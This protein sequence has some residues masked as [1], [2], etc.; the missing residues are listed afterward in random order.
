MKSIFISITVYG[1][2]INREI[3]VENTKAFTFLVSLK[4]SKWTF[5]VRVARTTTPKM[6]IPFTP[7]ST[8]DNQTMRLFPSV[9]QNKFLVYRGGL[10]VMSNSDVV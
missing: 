1:S 2:Q 10:L 5:L 4:L 8:T 3:A 7:Y 9:S 6:V